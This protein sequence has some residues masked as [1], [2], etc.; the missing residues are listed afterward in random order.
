M[1]LYQFIG[2]FTATCHLKML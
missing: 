2:I 1:A